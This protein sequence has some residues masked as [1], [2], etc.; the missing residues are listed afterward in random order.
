LL[1]IWPLDLIAPLRAG[2]IKLLKKREGLSQT[3]KKK[4]L[5]LDLIRPADLAAQSPL[6]L[7]K[8]EIYREKACRT[9]LILGEERLEHDSQREMSIRATFDVAL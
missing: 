7:K 2:I 1:Q 9:G 5:T 6:H 3:M 8:R 4:N